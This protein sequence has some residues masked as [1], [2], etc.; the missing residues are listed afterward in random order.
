[1]EVVS[2]LSEFPAN[3]PALTTAENTIRLLKHFPSGFPLMLNNSQHVPIIA[4]VQPG[5]APLPAS[6]PPGP[7]PPRKQGKHGICA[8]FVCEQTATTYCKRGEAACPRHHRGPSTKTEK[9]QMLDWFSKHPKLLLQA[10]YK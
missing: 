1:M 8:Y 5:L 9:D 10:K 6:G 3:I 4:A 2:Y 7:T